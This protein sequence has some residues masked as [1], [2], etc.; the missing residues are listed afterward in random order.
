MDDLQCLIIFCVPK[1]T[2]CIAVV[3]S[4][5]GDTFMTTALHNL[6]LGGY[7]SFTPET[8]GKG[9]ELSSLLCTAWRITPKK[10]ITRR[11]MR[12]EIPLNYIQEGCNAVEGRFFACLPEKTKKVVMEAY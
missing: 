7:D 2:P 3:P 6:I 11:E 1:V 12:P 10:Y 8:W 5:S 4:F 9:V